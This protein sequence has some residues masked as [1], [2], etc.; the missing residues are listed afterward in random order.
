MSSTL[1]SRR[2]AANAHLRRMLGF[3]LLVAVVFFGS[4]RVMTHYYD[5][6]EPPRSHTKALVGLSMLHPKH[7]H[8]PSWMREA[9]SD[10]WIKDA[11][12][13]DALGDDEDPD[14]PPT[15][16]RGKHELVPVKTELS[17][18]LG[19]PEPP[20]EAVWQR[21]DRPGMAAGVLF[22]AHGC[23]HAATDWWPKTESCAKCIGLPEEA[24]IVRAALRRDLLAVALSSSD[25]GS[26]CWGLNSRDSLRAAAA[27]RYFVDKERARSG[28]GSSWELPLLAV[29]ASSGG[30]FVSSPELAAA[31]K[32]QGVPLKGVNAQ[33]GVMNPPAMVPMVLTHMPERDIRTAERVKKALKVLDAASMHRLQQELHPLVLDWDFFSRRIDG[34]GSAASH[35]MVSALKDAG[36]VGAEGTLL[37]DPRTSGWRSI[38]ALRKAAKSDSLVADQSAISEELNV[39]FAAHE[40]SADAIDQALLFLL[41]YARDKPK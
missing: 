5:Y 28:A 38:G 32:A 19:V 17:D 23:S 12:N 22:L 41:S 39:A 3:T 8:R 35:A 6:Y 30:A 9:P 31:L 2:Q 14:D 20:V 40:I 13:T 36:H 37:A 18:E 1:T 11:V 10:E 15:E 29:G 25:R 24:R 33:I 7:V 27:L 16:L 34:V 21:P 4:G 26:G